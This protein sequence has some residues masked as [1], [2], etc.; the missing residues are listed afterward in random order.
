MAA[1][2]EFRQG[3]NDSNFA[4]FWYYNAYLFAGTLA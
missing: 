3:Y 2:I 1:L 4:Q